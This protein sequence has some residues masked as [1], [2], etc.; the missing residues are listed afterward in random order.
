ML[1]YTVPVFGVSRVFSFS[2]S[3]TPWFHAPALAMLWHLSLCLQRIVQDPRGG[4]GQV[5]FPSSYTRPVSLYMRRESFWAAYKNTWKLARMW[6]RV[7][8]VA[9]IRRLNPFL[10]VR[11]TLAGQVTRGQC[12]LVQCCTGQCHPVRRSALQDCAAECSTILSVRCSTV[13]A[14]LYRVA[15]YRVALHCTRVL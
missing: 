8:N 13:G 14:T 6:K 2:C 12:H 5:S 7:P 15:L 9:W 3:V 1:W 4:G 10:V 11:R